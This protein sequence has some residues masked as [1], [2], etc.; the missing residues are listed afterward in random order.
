MEKVT[1]GLRLIPYGGAEQVTGSNFLIEGVEGRILVDC[2]IEQGKDYCESCSFDDFPYDVPSIDALVIT[3]A[4]LDH[5]GRAPRLMKY[6]F[7]G[8]VYMTPPT[9]DLAELIVR[10]SAH[11]LA[12]NAQKQGLSPLYGDDEVNAFL[13]RIETLPYHEEREVAPGL[14]IMLRDT[15]HILGSASVRVKAKDGTT[16]AITS[17]IGASPAVLLPDVEPITD[18]D[19]VLIESVYGDRQNPEKEHRVPMLRETMQKAIERGGVIL[20]PSFSIERTQLMLYE[21][22]T[23][24]E[25]GEI[26]Q[27]PVYL[28]SPLAINVTAV[29]KKWG[30]EYFNKEA[31]Q[32]IS[33]DHDLFAFPFIKF[34]K[35]REESD[36]IARAESPKL[37]IAGAG[38]SHGGR[39]GKWEK[40][41]LPDPETTLIMVG[42]Q[43][44]GSPGRLM[45]DGV[46]KVKIDGHDVKLRAKVEVLHG[47]S[48]HADRDG[49]VSY[50]DSCK[51]AKTF[52]VGLGEPASAR[53]LAQRIHE[54]L[55]KRAIVLSKGEPLSIVK[56]EVKR[57][58]R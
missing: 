44:P 6:G 8:K 32:E 5:V 19:V 17:D 56:G 2:G 24:M 47:W 29:Y 22:G 10:D 31:K 49:L 14:S 27:I 26:P 7:Q 34:T 53:F 41:Y 54:F 58:V 42:Y 20:M 55:G 12:Q 57:M 30:K 16:L 50:A 3:H 46:K 23:M 45:Q 15:G 21:I 48:G 13:A 4:H 1:E 43:A 25:K 52:L 39:I 38:M 40:M 37:I 51:S 35:E 28:D 36:L 18:A 11:I 33:E 9:R